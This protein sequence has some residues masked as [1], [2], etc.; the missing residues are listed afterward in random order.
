MYSAN[1]NNF[2]NTDY[3]VYAIYTYSYVLTVSG[4]I[5]PSKL[6]H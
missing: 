2:S 5:V 6:K 4:F 3:A 1:F